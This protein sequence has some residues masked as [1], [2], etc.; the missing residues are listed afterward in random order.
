[1]TEDRGGPPPSSVVCRASSGLPL[2][3]AASLP[4]VA[5]AL[6]VV[7][8]LSWGFNQVAVKLALPEV[9]PLIQAA[10]RSTF[11]ALILLVWARLRGLKLVEPDGTLLPGVVSG[12]LFAVE[13]LL[14]YRG[15]VWT[16]ASRAGV[17]L[18]TAPFFVAIGARWLLP[19]ERFDRKQW[20]GLWL[21]FAGVVMAL[22]MPTPGG[23]PREL[24]G[25]VMLVMAGAA[26]GATTLLVKASALARTSSEKVLLYQLVVSAPLL[27]LGAY[28]LGERL[29]GLPSGLAIGS[30]MYQTIWVVAVTFLAW[31]ALVQR[32]SASRLSALTFLTPVFGV[33]AGHLVLGEPLTP[34]FAAAA[35]LVAAGLV[36]V[37]RRR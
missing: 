14:I 10:F 13:F 3:A 24:V 30:L 25:D 1:M 28:V 31:F 4:P 9:P 17:F 2:E 5:A 7:L 26:W 29:P 16:G 18:Y 15:L 34:A 11:G 33:A 21:C 22:G 35:A 32:Y 23:D 36:L 37:N 27:A 6:A 8:C 12:L 20:I 19:G